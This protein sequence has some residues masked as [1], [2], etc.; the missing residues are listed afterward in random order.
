MFGNALAM[1]NPIKA[2]YLLI[3]L[4]IPLFFLNSCVDDNNAEPEIPGSDREKFLGSWL[5][6]ETVTGNAPNTFT[7]N[8]QKQ[9]DGDTLKVVNFNNLGNPTSAYWIVVDN[10]INI[11]AQTITQVDIAGSGYFN[12]NKLI[13][14]YSSDGESVTAS[15][16]R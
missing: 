16:T 14:N 9:G 10:S 15:C 11:P 3:F 4:L 2:R 8:I 7:I 6:K 1:K 12:D 13:L 5:C